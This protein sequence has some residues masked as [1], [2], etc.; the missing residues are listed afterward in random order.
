MALFHIAGRD[1]DELERLLEFAEVGEGFVGGAHIGLAH[2]LD[3]R[4]AAAVQVDVGVAVGIA[5]AIVLALAGIIFHVDAGDADALL[6]AVHL[7]I[8]EA[9]LGERLIV[10]GNLIALGRIG[11]EIILARETR[12]A[13]DMCS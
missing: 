4:R 12:E 1:F 11:I 3:Q 7:D 2:D 10:H 8:D 5:E 6:P 9:V 13:A